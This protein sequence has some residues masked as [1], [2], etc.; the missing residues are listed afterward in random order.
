MSVERQDLDARDSD[1]DA[2]TSDPSGRTFVLTGKI[3]GVYSPGGAVTDRFVIPAYVP[4]ED[5]AAWIR[6]H[7]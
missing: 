1:G 5:I 4:D 6:A 2:L 3:V 7:R